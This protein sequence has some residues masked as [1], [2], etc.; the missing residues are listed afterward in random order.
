MG[1]ERG[2]GRTR[3]AV[4]G[5]VVCGCVAAVWIFCGEEEG[6]GCELRVDGGG[7]GGG[8]EGLGQFGGVAGA[9]VVEYVVDCVGG[10][11]GVFGCHCGVGW[12]V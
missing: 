1:E 11:G 9:G 6:G 3:V 4:C 2:G 7:G 10:E 12:W 8:E 5:G